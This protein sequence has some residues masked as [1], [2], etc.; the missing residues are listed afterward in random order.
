MTSL[1]VDWNGKTGTV[2]PS[3]E[4]LCKLVVA[5]LLAAAAEEPSLLLLQ[6]VMGLACFCVTYQRAIYA[7]FSGVF[8][9]MSAPRPGP[10]PEEVVDELLTA[11]SVCFSCVC[12]LKN[13]VD[14]V[15]VATDASLAGGGSCLGVELS[16]HGVETWVSHWSKGRAAAKEAATGFYKTPGVIETA[17]GTLVCD[18]RILI[19]SLFDGIGGISQAFKLAGIKVA[20][21]I[22]VES[23]AGCRRVVRRHFAVA[24]EYPDVALITA[25]VVDEWS[26][27][28]GDCQIFWSAGSPCQDLSS[29]QGAGRAGL[30]GS[31]SN[32]FWHVP[33]IDLLLSKSFGRGR[34]AGLFEN[35]ATMEAHDVQT[36]SE[37]FEVQP[38]YINSSG[39]SRVRR[40]RFYWLVN[41]SLQMSGACDLLQQR[42]Q[43][44]ELIVRGDGPPLEFFIQPG[45]VAQL[46][47]GSFYPTLTRPLP[48]RAEPE[49]A[50]GFSKSSAGAIERWKA[51][52]WRH[53]PYQ[54][55]EDY[56]VLED[57]VLR[58]LAAIEKERLMGFNSNYTSYMDKAAPK[59]GCWTIQDRRADAIG[60]SFHCIVV[61]HLVSH[62]FAM[63]PEDVQDATQIWRRFQE[64]EKEE[65]EWHGVLENMEVKNFDRVLELVAA[66]AEPCEKQV[67]AKAVKWELSQHVVYNHLRMCDHKGSDVRLNPSQIFRPH[68]W[69]RTSLDM[70]QWTWKVLQSYAFKQTQHINVLEMRAILNY[71]RM[72]CRD[73]RKHRA[74]M[75]LIVD[76]QV[77]CSVV[78]KGRSSSQQLNAVLRR[79]SGLVIATDTRIAVG[80]C[81]SDQNPADKPSR[82]ICR[83]N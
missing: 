52:D 8:H 70:K 83:R 32:A 82:E 46:P 10:L 78:A 51:N 41:Y 2:G 29:L 48:K 65:A 68:A 59:P 60:N 53:Q 64:M 33:R 74:R 54:Y 67:A 18:Q 75:L 6:E 1:G 39:C 20:G 22:V 49:Y 11:A 57:D 4:R 31:K 24:M 69:P 50:A 38:I 63:K 62:A 30:L 3:G 14:G 28:F 21:L 44:G 12:H 42:K 40:P 73:T 79:M 27:T 9:W 45:G 19:V 26:Q 61:A 25:A 58:P 13:E 23:D 76:S 37:A 15:P 43:S 81:Q 77:V 7:C 34:V 36:I 71:M 5:L 66:S 16:P 17:T 47:I 80:W 35:V 55:E 56:M 72:R